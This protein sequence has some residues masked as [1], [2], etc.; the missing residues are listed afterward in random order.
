MD[1]LQD[2]SN[3]EE[4]GELR[5]PARELLTMTQP[6]IAT[7]IG[8]HREFGKAMRDMME[9][10]LDQM[11]SP[12]GLLLAIGPYTLS[13]RLIDT[14]LKRFRFQLGEIPMLGTQ[15]QAVFCSSGEKVECGIKA[16]GCMGFKG[17]DLEVSRIRNIRRRP[18]EKARALSRRPQTSRAAVQLLFP[19][20][21]YYPQTV[22]NPLR[23]GGKLNPLGIYNTRLASKTKIFNPI[24]GMINKMQNIFNTGIPYSAVWDFIDTYRKAHLDTRFA[25]AFGINTDSF[26]RVF[27]FCNWQGSTSDLVIGKISASGLK[28]AIGL[29]VG[30]DRKNEKSLGFG[31]SLPGGVVTK[32]KISPE[33]AVNNSESSNEVLMKQLSMDRSLWDRNTRSTL[34][35]SV[36]HP[37]YVKKRPNS[38]REVQDCMDHSKNGEKNET[39]CEMDELP[40]LYFLMANPY[41]KATLVTAPDQVIKKVEKGEAIGFLGSQ[42]VANIMSSVED[43]INTSLKRT[44][45]SKI[46]GG[47]LIECSNRAQALEEQFRI[48]L[49]KYREVLAFPFLGFV[50]SGEIAPKEYPIVCS[51]LVS[52]LFGQ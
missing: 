15:Q 17:L 37:F 48:L 36:F 46:Y 42:T 45:L 14:E 8:I 6:K 19:P 10:L 27:Q 29:G 35:I 30:V 7:S 26:S 4:F 1:V 11:D 52:V 16:V 47:I 9:G 43:A 24:F 18:K 32:L 22:L 21:I 40:S 50:T 34:G 39:P 2:P 28:T 5:T 20:G 44:P 12:E 38:L 3:D 33:M 23:G 13:K 25:G 49:E 51:S 31:R 41:M